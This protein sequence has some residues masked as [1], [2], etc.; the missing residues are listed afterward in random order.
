MPTRPNTS[1]STAG[2]AE[3]FRSHLVVVSGH[4]Q[5]ALAAAGFDAAIVT[6]GEPRNHFLDD[7]APPL[8]LNP[9]FLQWCPADTAAGSALLIRPGEQPGL[10]FLRQEDYWHL[11]PELPEWAASFEVQTFPD[12]AALQAAL[13]TAAMKAGNH[14]ALVGDLSADAGQ[15]AGIGLPGSDVN[16]SLLLDHLHF[17]RA[18][19]TE[20]E[21]QAMKVATSKAVRGHLAARRAFEMGQ[22]EFQINLA[23]LEACGQ[24][25]AELPY[26]NIVA[27]NEH[28]GVLH[29]QH[30]DQT[31]PATR[32]SFLIDAGGSHCGYA[33]DITRTYSASNGRFAEL[34]ARL[35][36]A[37]QALIETMSSGMPYLD[38]H[39]RMHRSLAGI[40]ADAGLVSCSAEEA[41]DKRLSEIF[42]PHGLGHLIGL[43]THDVGG[44]QSAPEGG[45]RLPPEN[46]AALRLTRVLEEKMPV[47]IEPGLY[48]I[49][50]LLSAAR[51]SASGRLIN[52]PVIDSLLP[53][54]G[55]RIEDNVYLRDDEPVNLTRDAFAEL[56]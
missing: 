50:Q 43:Q 11:P 25:P 7:Q 40:L 38:L 8:K 32:H 49:P 27:L 53:C 29:Y 22:S 30:Y 36:A 47:T 34:V 1:S 54:G 28:A 20:F 3:L 45:T 12:R 23:Y 48:F 2:I 24:L 18:V 46:Y 35:D 13:H 31:P 19:K 42:L 17:S 39:V 41:H 37:Q 52:W 4:W 51:D 26:Q 14:I 44:L 15:V 10:F 21:L 33:A 9:H 5:D 56:G 16:P 55:I 6:A